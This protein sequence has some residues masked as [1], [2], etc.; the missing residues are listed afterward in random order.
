VA[1]LKI[2]HKR[3]WS[4]DA[5]CFF[6]AALLLFAQALLIQ[7]A[8]LS[9]C[10]SPPQSRDLVVHCNLGRGA[11]PSEAQDEETRY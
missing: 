3:L 7:R 11:K 10:E 4:R 9:F 6:T 5:F 2:R 8:I 1:S